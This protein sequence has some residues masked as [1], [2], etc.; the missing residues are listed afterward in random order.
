MI[1]SAC[2]SL[3]SKLVGEDSSLGSP[4]DVE[5]ADK[6]IQGRLANVLKHFIGFLIFSVGP[7][8]SYTVLGIMC[9]AFHI[10]IS[11]PK[12]PYYLMQV[13]RSEDARNA[14]IK[15]QPAG[16]DDK[17]LDQRLDEIAN[18]YHPASLYPLNIRPGAIVSAMIIDRLGRKPVLL[19]SYGLCGLALLSKGIYFY[20]QDFAHAND[21]TIS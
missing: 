20:L 11:M 17:T 3:S 4:M 5:D 13:E 2:M 1:L 19:I 9:A 16:V 10:F 12:S 7:F 8:V 18:S 15:F 6:D 21:D 14:L